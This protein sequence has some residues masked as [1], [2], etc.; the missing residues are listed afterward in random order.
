MSICDTWTTNCFP[1]WTLILQNGIHYG[2][3][4]LGQPFYICQCMEPISCKFSGIV[5][6]LQLLRHASKSKCFFD[7]NFLKK[8]INLEYAA[9]IAGRWQWP[10]THVAFM[11]EPRILTENSNLLGCVTTE[12]LRSPQHFE[13]MSCTSSGLQ[14]PWGWKQLIPSKHKD[15]LIQWCIVTSQKTK[16]LNTVFYKNPLYLNFLTYKL[17]HNSILRSS[18]HRG[19]EIKTH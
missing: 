8:Y 7:H 9:L 15:A 12:L 17:Q 13:K 11:W 1:A 16:I 10:S 4:S 14:G 2:V 19:E 3:P 18:T 6:W 5:Q